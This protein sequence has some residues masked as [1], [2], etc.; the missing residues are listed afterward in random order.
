MTF[1]GKCDIVLYNK[2]YIMRGVNL[3]RKKM[4]VLV[5]GAGLPLM[6]D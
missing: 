3:K 6:S 2:K 1:N 4:V 5:A